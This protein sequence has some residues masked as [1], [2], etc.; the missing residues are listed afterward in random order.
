MIISGLTCVGRPAENGKRAEPESV[1]TFREYTLESLKAATKGFNAE[2]IVS[3]SGEKAPNSVY[4][5]KLDQ[6]LIAVKRFPFSA[7]P[8]AKGF[9]V[10]LSFLSPFPHF[11]ALFFVYLF[12]NMSRTG[13]PV[14]FG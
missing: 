2:L 1:P 9:A 8:D 14:E 12:L 10:L 5:G 7:W 3:E 4:K 11:R 6:K 13:S